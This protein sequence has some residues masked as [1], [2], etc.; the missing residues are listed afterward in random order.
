MPKRY[1]LW[2]QSSPYMG[3]LGPKYIPFGYMTLGVR[4]TQS[5]TGPSVDGQNPA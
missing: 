2:P 3:A 1:I 5:N 4:R